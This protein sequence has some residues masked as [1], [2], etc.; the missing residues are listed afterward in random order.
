MNKQVVCFECP[1][2]ADETKG[3]N[4]RF[5]AIAYVRKKNATWKLKEEKKPVG[6]GNGG[7]GGRESVVL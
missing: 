1:E 5:I 2:R 3:E 7:R 4:D 6:D